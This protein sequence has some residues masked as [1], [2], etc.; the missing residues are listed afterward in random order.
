M[1]TMKVV[2]KFL[3]YISIILEYPI[4]LKNKKMN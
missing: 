4:R 2:L 1:Q 3:E